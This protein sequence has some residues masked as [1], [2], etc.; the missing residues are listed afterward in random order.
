M[1]VYEPDGG[2]IGSGSQLFVAQHRSSTDK[3][4][5][6]GRITFSSPLAY[7]WHSNLNRLAS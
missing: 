6:L 2:D 7:I 3:Y 5:H 4:N 1:E